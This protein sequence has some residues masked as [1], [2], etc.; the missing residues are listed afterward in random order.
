VVFSG[1][2]YDPEDGSLPPSALSW[3]SDKDGPLGTGT[4]LE[5][6][7]L[8]FGKHVITLTATDSDSQ[9][10]TATV[11]IAIAYPAYLPVIMR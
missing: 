6:D 5:L 1:Y 10:A 8:S 11:N 9:T 7:T 4:T 3:A 2:A